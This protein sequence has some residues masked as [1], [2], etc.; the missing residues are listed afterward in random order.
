MASIIVKTV[1][2]AQVAALHMFCATT[3]VGGLMLK[4]R[5]DTGGTE[6][7]PSPSGDMGGTGDSDS[8]ARDTQIWSTFADAEC[9]RHCAKDNA[10]W[11]W[12][13]ICVSVLGWVLCSIASVMFMTVV[14]SIWSLFGDFPARYGAGSTHVTE[15]ESDDD[16]FGA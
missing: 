12:F 11:E 8:T 10:C 13:W 3:D 4:P 7:A 5:G 6:V 16:I 9:C 15:P 1:A 2:V 14:W